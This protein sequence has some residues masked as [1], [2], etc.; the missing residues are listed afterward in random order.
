MAHQQVKAFTTKLV[1]YLGW[2]LG[3]G[4]SRLPQVVF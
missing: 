4:E 2:I 1:T 3:E